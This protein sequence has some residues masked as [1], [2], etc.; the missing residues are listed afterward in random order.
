ML[1][2]RSLLSALATLPFIRGLRGSDDVHAAAPYADEDNAREFSW[3]I[4][5]IGKTT[6]LELETLTTAMRN[7][8]QWVEFR[9]HAPFGECG[10][11]SLAADLKAKCRSLGLI[12]DVEV[13]G[14]RVWVRSPQSRLHQMNK[15]HWRAQATSADPIEF[16]RGPVCLKLN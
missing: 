9:D 13:S 10:A 14:G 5:F 8:D 12:M 7:P 6:L 16:D 3:Q 1:T 11:E 2:R 4:K 15:E